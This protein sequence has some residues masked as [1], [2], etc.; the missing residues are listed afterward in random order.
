MKDFTINENVKNLLLN[1]KFLELVLGSSYGESNTRSNASDVTRNLLGGYTH[2]EISEAK[3]I[4]SNLDEDL[5][6]ISE[7]DV[8]ELKKRIKKCLKAQ[9]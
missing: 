9:K 4:L 2:E 7:K 3:Y 1:P 5:G 6:L 8:E